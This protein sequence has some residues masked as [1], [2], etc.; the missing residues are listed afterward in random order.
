[1]TAPTSHILAVKLANDPLHNMGVP[2]QLQ[3]PWD[4]YGAVGW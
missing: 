1:M 3:K 2:A 4:C